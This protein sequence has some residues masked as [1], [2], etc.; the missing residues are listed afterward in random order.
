MLTIRL[1]SPEGMTLRY[2]SLHSFNMKQYFCNFYTTLDAPIERGSTVRIT[3]E[4]DES[5]DR[6]LTFNGKTW[7]VSE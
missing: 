5:I 1:V 3:D 6:T 4:E 7:E 2:E